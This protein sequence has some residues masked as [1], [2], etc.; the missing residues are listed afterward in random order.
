MRD[1]RFRT[2][3]LGIAACVAALVLLVVAVITGRTGYSH[4]V[5]RLAAHDTQRL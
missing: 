5:A 2:H 1:K 4:A 3:W